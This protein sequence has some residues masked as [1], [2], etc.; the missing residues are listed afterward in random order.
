MPSVTRRVCRL[1]LR[2]ASEE[3]LRRAELVLEDAMRTA[4]L[5]DEGGRILLVRRLALGRLRSG[6]R[7]EQVARTLE[8]ALEVAAADCRH[9]TEPAAGQADMV[10]FADALEAH[11]ALAR[12]LLGGPPP[13]AWY[14]RLVARSWRPE[15]GVHVGLVALARSLRALPEA[16]VALPAWVAALVHDGHGRAL[17]GALEATEVGSAAEAL[18]LPSAETSIGVVGR[19]AIDALRPPPESV[20]SAN[21]TT[22]GERTPPAT[23][24]SGPR[25]LSNAPPSSTV[26]TEAG[27]AGRTAPAPTSHAQETEAHTV[28]ELPPLAPGAPVEARPPGRGPRSRRSPPLLDVASGRPSG[29]AS[30]KAASRRRDPD[31]SATPT[32]PSAGASAPPPSR[33]PETT[34]PPEHEA[35]LWPDQSATRAGGIAFVLNVLVRLGYAAWLEGRPVWAERDVARRVLVRIVDGLGVPREDPVR[36]LI[37][38]TGPVGTVY[39]VQGPRREREAVV[40]RA[41]SLAVHGWLRRHA[42]VGMAELVLRPG[43][44]ALSRTHVDVWFD[45]EACDLRIRRAGLDLDP[46]WLDWLGRVVAFHYQPTGAR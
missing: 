21:G 36:A 7:A 16:A 3:A 15:D 34:D 37:R 18:G 28:V 19:Q 25:D 6:A 5:R 31:R 13:R 45:P 27:D 42:G 14:W 39:A 4:S 43:S 9:G 44:L 23:R 26:E 22:D 40:V 20:H 8:D 41:W 2:G 30:G 33:T 12:R 38:P 11:L 29:G 1:R 35:P 10:W 32:A 17:A 24:R 46:G